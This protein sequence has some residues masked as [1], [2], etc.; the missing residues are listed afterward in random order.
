[1]ANAYL[2][3]PNLFDFAAAI[4]A[5]SQ[6]QSLPVQN[7]RD[8][9]VV[10]P[11][12]GAV[13]VTTTYLLADNGAAK[14]LQA[15]A[16]LGTNL[17][18]NATFRVRVSASDQT[19]VAGDLYDSGT[20][21]AGQVDPAYRAFVHSLPAPVSGRYVR[22]DITDTNLSYLEAGRWFFGP[23]FQ[24]GINIQFGLLRNQNDPSK[25]TESLNGQ[26]FVDRKDKRRSWRINFD[27]LTEQEA[28]TGLAEIDRL[29]SITDDVL[30]VLDPDS[31]NLGRDSIWGL[32][33]QQSG[34]TH[35]NQD[36]FQQ[37]Y[38]ITE[39]K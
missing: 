19:G 2:G 33:S 31:T 8:P 23:V 9:R 18:A 26:V 34:L 37:S 27:F 36:T 5:G 28:L 39:R 16:L 21:A 15:T 20:I 6:I 1:M 30:F 35:S 13:G 4:G 29:V 32:L 10:R 38:T 25:L 11:W 24:P 14:E 22:L 7:L 12:R 3:A 17:T